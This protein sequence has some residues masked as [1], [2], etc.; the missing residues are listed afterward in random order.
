MHE[1]LCSIAKDIV[2]FI[3]FCVLSK[4]IIKWIKIKKKIPYFR[5]VSGV[6]YK[7]SPEDN[8]K[9]SI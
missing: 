7:V 2:F 4:Q 9:K 3:L 1:V 8:N 6:G 5:K